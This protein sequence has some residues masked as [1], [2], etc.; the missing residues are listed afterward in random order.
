MPDSP[1]PFSLSPLQTSSRKKIKFA[2]AVFFF[3]S[4]FGY[5]AWASRI[6]TIKQH[7]HLSE[8]ELGS[9]LFAMPVGL[10]ATMP[11]T[12]YLLGRFPSRSILFFGALLFNL[13]LCLTGWWRHPG[14]WLFFCLPS[15]PP[16]TFST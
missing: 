10:M 13:A 12:K 11:L 15:V 1:Q 6:P 8:A 14:N 3:I 4:G 7:L 2:C 5:A 9:I 16:E